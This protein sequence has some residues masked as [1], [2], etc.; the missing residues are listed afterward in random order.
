MKS[1]YRAILPVLALAALTLGLSAC[2]IFKSPT[3]QQ[4]V[5]AQCV[6]I[7]GDAAIIGASP[8]LNAD[9]QKFVNEKFLPANK[10]VCAGVATLNVN[11]ADLKTLHDSLLPAVV[12]LVQ[13]LPAFPN[14]TAI[15]LGLNT[16][17]PLLQLEVDQI[18]MATQKTAPASSPAPA[19]A[20]LAASALTL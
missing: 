5:A 2:S 6:I 18:I 16:F 12:T 10:A 4:Q 3:V 14:Q 1:L 15:L 19:S 8:L 17:G 13:G 9:Q 11:A 20:P 7:N